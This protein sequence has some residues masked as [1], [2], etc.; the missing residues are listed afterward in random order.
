MGY[1]LI[2]F[3][4]ISITITPSIR[5]AYW[6][7]KHS[8]S[9]WHWPQSR[10]STKLSLQSSELGPPSTAGECVRPSFCSLWRGGGGEGGPNSDERTDIVENYEDI[11]VFAIF[12]K[13]TL[14]KQRRSQRSSLSFWCNVR[15][16]CWP[17]TEGWSRFA[18]RAS[19]KS[20]LPN[21]QMVV[22]LCVSVQCA[23]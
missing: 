16:S 8:Q 5:F 11:K 23:M 9:Q 22:S 21:E 3:D 12:Q 4:H 20:A 2:F 18:E 7:C 17:I 19:I 6:R 13:K 1:V 15:S 14:P 10:Q